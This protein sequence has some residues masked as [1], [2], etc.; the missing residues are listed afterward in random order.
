MRDMLKNDIKVGDK[1]LVYGV[2][3]MNLRTVRELLEDDMFTVE[4]YNSLDHDSYRGYKCVVV[5]Q[6][7]KHNLDILPERFV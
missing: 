2:N 6:Q 4:E 3:H 7:L 1:V 5:T